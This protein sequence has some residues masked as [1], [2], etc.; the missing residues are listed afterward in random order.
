MIDL[1]GIARQKMNDIV[2]DNPERS[3]HEKKGFSIEYVINHDRLALVL[4]FLLNLKQTLSVDIETYRATG[5]ENDSMGGLDPYRSEIRLV[6]LYGG[7]GPVYVFDL[8]KLGGLKVLGSGIWTRPM[9]AHNAVFELKHLINKGSHPR[10]MGCTMLLANALCGGKLRSLKDLTFEVLGEDLSKEQQTSDW[11]KDDLSQEQIEYAAK[12]AIVTYKI[13]HAL[14]PKLRE[15]GL[16]KTY[17]VMR[18]AQHAIARIELAG[19]RI[20]EKSHASLIHMWE[21]NKEEQESI[22]RET[23]GSEMNLNST[24][25]LGEWIKSHVDVSLWPKTEKGH[26]KVDAF[27]LS[28]N[29]HLP[30]TEPLLK[31]K[32][33]SKLLNTYGKSFADHINPVT[34]RIHASFRLGGTATGRLSCTRPNIQNPPRDPAF[35]KLFVAERGNVLVV[36][37][38]SQIELRVAAL[39]SG[40]KEML[41]AYKN[42]EDL[43]KK[44]AAAVMGISPNEVSKEQRQ[45]AKAVNFGLLFGMSAKRLSGYAKY[46]YGVEMSLEEA[47]KARKAFFDTYSGLSMWQKK[48]GRMSSAIQKA[49][50]PLGRIRDF[51]K[52]GTGYRYTEALNTPVQGGAAEAMLCTL[53]RLE[54]AI[55]WKRAKIVNVIH[56]EVIIEC[57]EEMGEDIKIIIENA[58]LDG[59]LDVFPKAGLYTKDLVEAHINTNWKDAK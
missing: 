23:L 38:F 6:Q 52:D 16:E 58:M 13:F 44:T 35:R 49:T 46:N 3:S 36:A 47:E 9:V 7:E 29:R 55:D 59:F 43:H 28:Q 21:K 18:N 31:Y 39:V 41:E 48:T 26:L 24:K 8:K 32:E 17:E 20:D 30:I 14:H 25:Q 34:G 27:A 22:L 1:L 53:V 51:Q 45:M 40:D 15:L 56:D 5:F 33:M 19:I 37:D 50:T 42:G 57:A 11:S 10:L 4:E 2:S 54:K 12:D